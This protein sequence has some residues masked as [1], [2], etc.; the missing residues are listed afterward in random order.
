MLPLIINTAIVIII[1][2]YTG[3]PDVPSFKLHNFRPRKFGNN[4]EMKYSFRRARRNFL[5][6]SEGASRR[7]WLNGT[8]GRLHRRRCVHGA[9]NHDPVSWSL[10][11]KSTCA[12]PSRTGLLHR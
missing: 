2:L 9:A 5:G 4:K 3:I 8:A 1:L 6:G 7:R 12:G 11:F 10:D